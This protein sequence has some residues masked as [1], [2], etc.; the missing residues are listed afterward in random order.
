MVIKYMNKFMIVTDSCSDIRGEEV[1][2]LDVE[3]VPMNVSFGDEHYQEG[4]NITPE[5]FYNKLVSSKIFPKTS[6]PSPDLFEEIFLRAKA[7]SREVLVLCLS[8]GLSGTLQSAKIAAGLA[9]Y[10]EHIHFV[11]TL[12]CLTGERLI[13]KEACRLRDE[14]VPLENVIEILEDIKHRVRYFSIVDTLEYFHKGGRLSKAALILGSLV[15]IKPFIDLD[16]QGKIRNFGKGLGMHRSLRAAQDFV[17]KYERDEKYGVCYGYVA[18]D[19]NLK[20]LIEKTSNILNV[21][22]IDVSAI[23]ATSGAHIGPGGSCIAY[24]SKEIKE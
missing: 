12:A 3:V 2:K 18:D 8:S 13:V 14:G 24:I 15:G 6:Q 11:D 1:T 17:K 20:K 10:E 23:G 5:E 21:D 7:T 16:P 19:E 22:E 4:V 9:E